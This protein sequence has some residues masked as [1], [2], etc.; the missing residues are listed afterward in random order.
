MRGSARPVR[1][2]CMLDGMARRG[3]DP[4]DP[5]FRED[6]AAALNAWRVGAELLGYADA[7]ER[8]AHEAAIAALVPDLERFSSFGSLLDH[9]LAEQPA[10]E[11][12]A[13]AACVGAAALRPRVRPL[14]KVVLHAAFWRRCR[15]LVAEATAAPRE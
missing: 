2:A 1:P 10:A 11:R 7:E 5:R 14:S 6:A 4:R 9:Y 12:A 15:A 13:Q 3:T 8:A